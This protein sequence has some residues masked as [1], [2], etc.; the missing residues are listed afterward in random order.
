MNFDT[1]YQ[2][3]SALIISRSHSAL[4]E[5]RIINQTPSLYLEALS[6]NFNKQK[7]QENFGI[8]GTVFPKLISMIKT[9]SRQILRGTMSNMFLYCRTFHS[10]EY[11]MCILWHQRKTQFAEFSKLIGP[12]KSCSQQT[13]Q[14]LPEQGLTESQFVKHR[15]TETYMKI[16]QLIKIFPEH[17]FWFCTD[18]HQHLHRLQICF[19]SQQVIQ[20]LIH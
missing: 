18:A 20:M 16:F 9:N 3:L 17:N 8:T 10:L 7:Q 13:F 2:S 4:K 19:V 5:P 15:P 14:Y 11:I 12:Q 1:E 6:A